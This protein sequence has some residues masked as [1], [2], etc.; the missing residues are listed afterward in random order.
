MWYIYLSTQLNLNC[1]PLEGCS[2]SVNNVN[3]N[4]NNKV[5]YNN[6]RGAVKMS[7]RSLMAL[8]QQQRKA[9]TKSNNKGQQ[10]G[11]TRS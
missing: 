9:T 10:Q 11:E 5:Q 8:M 3:K 2:S 1:N 7:E 6:S 4:L